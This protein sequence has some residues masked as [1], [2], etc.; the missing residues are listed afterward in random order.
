MRV[1]APFVGDFATGFIF[2]F[3]IYLVIG[4]KEDCSNTSFETGIGFGIVGGIFLLVKTG[5]VRSELAA[6]REEYTEVLSRK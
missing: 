6:L 3:L 2:N 4:S 5:I 1:L